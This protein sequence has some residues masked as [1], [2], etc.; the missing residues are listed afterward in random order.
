MD[1]AFVREVVSVFHS[2]KPDLKLSNPFERPQLH[3]ATS[4]QLRLGVAL[5]VCQLLHKTNVEGYQGFGDEIS[6]Q[7][8][9][10]LL[11]TIQKSCVNCATKR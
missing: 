4:S 7:F 8:T 6:E 2:L 10:V 11:Q 1:A 9:S 5:P 3:D